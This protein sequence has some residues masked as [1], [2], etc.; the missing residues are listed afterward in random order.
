MRVSCLRPGRESTGISPAAIS[1]RMRRLDQLALGVAREIQRERQ[2]DIFLWRERLEHRA[3][4]AGEGDAADGRPGAV[5]R[6]CRTKWGCPTQ[7]GLFSE[8]VRQFT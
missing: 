3:G 7:R 4:G 5:S 1:A 2:T 8:P 6:L